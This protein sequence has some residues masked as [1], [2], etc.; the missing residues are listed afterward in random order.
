MQNKYRCSSTI[1]EQFHSLSHPGVKSTINLIR[2]RFVWPKIA[3]DIKQWVRECVKC[4]QAKIQR[5]VKPPV[6]FD[7]PV[8]ERFQAI[9]VDIVD[10]FPLS[11]QGEKYLVTMIDRASRWLEA[12]S[13]RDIEAET[14]AQAILDAWICRFGVPLYIVTDQG[15]QF[16]SLLFENL[17]KVVG[18]HKLRSSAYQPQTNGIIERLHHTIKTFLRAKGEHWRTSFPVV[19]MALR[20][21]PNATGTSPFTMLTGSQML[22]PHTTVCRQENYSPD[23]FVKI[24]SKHFAEVDFHTLSA[25]TFHG[26]QKT[27][28]TIKFEKLVSCVGTG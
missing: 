22:M 28:H 5:H 26:S 24:L 10:P 16:E 8:N 19:L 25:G 15:R 27:I 12:V 20:C 21:M 11:K 6:H 1:L 9:D 23:E 17:R 13:T 2:S 7:L 3:T 4:Q 14:I 18:F